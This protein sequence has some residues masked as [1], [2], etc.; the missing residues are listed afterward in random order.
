MSHLIRL[1][2]LKG[3]EAIAYLVT[4]KKAL[5]AE[6]KAT[7]K[8][9]DIVTAPVSFIEMKGEGTIKSE[10]DTPV[11]TDGKLYVMTVCNSTFVFDSHQDVSLPGSYT[12]TCKEN[13]KNIPHICDH[14]HS[15]NAIL[16]ETIDTY[17][18]NIPFA[19]LGL[20]GVGELEC[21]VQESYVLKEYNAKVYQLYADKRIR[22]H[23]IALSYVS[24]SLA[25]NNPDY[26]EEYAVWE[27]YYNDIVNK[28][29]VDMYGY[30]WAIHEQK[31]WENSAV[32]FGSNFV[33]PTI[34]TGSKS[35]TVEEPHK[36]TPEQP[37]KA[38]IDFGMLVKQ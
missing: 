4:N 8:R 29:D 9:S 21:L 6:K 26:K 2:E 14:D 30:F 10:S 36:S 17:P 24:L 11:S 1:K 31:V 7:L 37:Q 33:T 19:R 25:I 18:K 27:K 15:V 5:L 12:K 20:K 28:E 34:E 16:G 32:L 23:S 3:K 38:K 35:G 22:Q 13:G